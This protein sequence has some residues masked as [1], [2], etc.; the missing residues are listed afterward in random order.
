M[1]E[2]QMRARARV[3]VCV[4]VCVCVRW[5][6]YCTAVSSFTEYIYV[7]PLTYSIQKFETKER[8]HIC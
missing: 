2:C 3:C 4:C 7:S 5:D 6:W 8:G 1:P